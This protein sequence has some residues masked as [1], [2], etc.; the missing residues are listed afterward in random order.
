MEALP[1]GELQ[2]WGCQYLFFTDV[3]LILQEREMPF[4]GDFFF[5]LDYYRCHKQ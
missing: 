3:K 4:P 1:K 2:D 5:F